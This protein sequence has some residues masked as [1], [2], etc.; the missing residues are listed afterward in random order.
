MER[1]VIPVVALNSMDLRK[2]ERR[3]QS[4]QR[5]CKITLFLVFLH[6][7]EIISLT[8]QKHFTLTIV[9]SRQRDFKNKNK[10]INKMTNNLILVSNSQWMETQLKKCIIQMN[11]RL[12]QVRLTRRKGI[13][14]YL[15]LL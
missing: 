1:E 9:V 15:I 11:L 5:H 7:L 10:V 13:A 6:R 3:L 12:Q 4:I 8:I 2:D 14:S